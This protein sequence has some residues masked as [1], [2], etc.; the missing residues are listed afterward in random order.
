[1][2]ENPIQSFSR[3]LKKKASR[4]MLINPRQD[5]KAAAAAALWWQN[6]KKRKKEANAKHWK[7]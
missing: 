1:M 3:Q 6:E 4:I 7:H 5:L 2:V